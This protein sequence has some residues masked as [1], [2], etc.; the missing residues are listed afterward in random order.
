VSSRSILPIRQFAASSRASANA[1][2]REL[3]VSLSKFAHSLKRRAEK[4]ARLRARHR[5]AAKV[6]R[7]QSH[8]PFGIA[9]ASSAGPFAGDRA[10]CAGLTDAASAFISRLFSSV[11]GQPAR[12]DSDSGGW[13]C[14]NA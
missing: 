7:A 14:W 6:A 13:L 9:S 1:R 3:R 5:S 12:V 4:R 2:R 11:M 8:D 10:G